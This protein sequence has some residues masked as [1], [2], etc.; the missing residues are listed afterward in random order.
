M[1]TAAG[2]CVRCGTAHHFRLPCSEPGLAANPRF[3]STEVPINWAAVHRTTR[4]AATVST[5]GPRAKF[6]LS[7]PPVIM[8]A[9]WYYVGVL[10]VP[11]FAVAFGIPMAAAAL[12]WFRKVWVSDPAPR[13]ASTEP[14]ASKAPESPAP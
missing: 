8:L 10:R 7:S 1:T 13:P 3:L 2:A 14:T 6:A 5:F 11:L 12:W 4:W 9:F